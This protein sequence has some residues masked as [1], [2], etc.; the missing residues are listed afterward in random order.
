MK[1]S[2]NSASCSQYQSEESWVRR[3][4]RAALARSTYSAVRA[5][6]T[7]RAGLALPRVIAF[8]PPAARLRRVAMA[9][10]PARNLLELHPRV[11]PC[12]R[13]NVK[14]SERSNPHPRLI[15]GRVLGQKDK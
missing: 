4:K 9:S 3:R 6:A 12:A 15:A 7:P 2:R 13:Q 5:R 10:P 11:Q 8:L 14:K 1:V